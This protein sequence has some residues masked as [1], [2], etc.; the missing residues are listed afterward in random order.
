M[1]SVKFAYG[2]GIEE[3]IYIRFAKDT[4]L[5]P[6]VNGKVLT[7]QIDIWSEKTHEV[8]RPKQPLMSQKF[9]TMHRWGFVFYVLLQTFW[10]FVHEM[11]W[12]YIMYTISKTFVKTRW[13]FQSWLDSHFTIDKEIWLDVTAHDRWF[14]VQSLVAAE[15]WPWD[16]CHFSA[17]E[18]LARSA[19]EAHLDRISFLSAPPPP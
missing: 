15:L 3:R 8:T 13:K 9:G 17:G 1:N 18:I 11:D 16:F 5:W 7:N 2:A 6:S 12:N 19:A 14:K 10:T 4:F